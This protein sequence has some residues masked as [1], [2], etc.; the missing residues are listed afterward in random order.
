LTI[1]VFYDGTNFRLKGWKKARR[2]IEKVISNE[3]RISGDLNFIITN[4]NFLRDINIK[5]LKHDYNTD[6]I[7]FNYNEGGIVNGEVYISLDTVKRNSKNYKVS[8]K[9]ELIRVMIHGALH[10]CGYDDKTKKEK[11]GMKYLEDKWL[12]VYYKER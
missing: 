8:L 10:L 3:N 2:I 6:V 7:T 5:F 1:R 11:K 9:N 12:M 4:D